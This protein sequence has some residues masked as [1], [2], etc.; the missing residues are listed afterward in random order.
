M[1]DPLYLSFFL[2]CS[3]RLPLMAC[4]SS[5]LWSRLAE[6]RI[7]FG[8]TSSQFGLSLFVLG[9]FF[10][11]VIDFGLSIKWTEVAKFF[12]PIV[13]NIYISSPKKKGTYYILIVTSL[14]VGLKLQIY[15]SF[16]LVS[17]KKKK[18][19]FHSHLFHK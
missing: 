10:F 14:E 7:V 1:A 8:D 3:I 15:I 13:L 9:H 5:L 11:L 6:N 2:G 4:R 17:R 18:K 12:D 19:T 16:S